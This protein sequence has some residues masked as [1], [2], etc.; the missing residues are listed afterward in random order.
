M[1]NN[2]IELITSMPTEQQCRDFYAKC[3]WT[4]GKPVCVHC[5]STKVYTIQGGKR[6][7]CGE[8]LCKKRFSVTCGTVFHAS[9]IPLTKWFMAVYL[10]INHKKGISSYQLGRDIGVTQKTGW[11]MLHRI[12]QLM[13][14]EDNVMLNTVVEIDETWI[15]GKMKNKHKAV[16]AKAH[17]SNIS[18]TDDKQAVMGYLQR[19][20]I[21]K[22]NKMKEDKTL[23]EQVKDNVLPEAV[24][25][26]DGL[27]AYKGLDKT[28]EAHEIVNHK[29]D[30]YVRGDIH[31]NSIEGAFGLFKRMVLGIYHKI[32]SKHLDRYCGEFCYRYNSRKIK[33]CD[34]FKMSLT[35]TEKRITYKALTGKK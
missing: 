14:P 2:L 21:L 20:G 30:E 16:R 6:Y 19:D 28:F 25:I 11:F 8:K 23:K 17:A 12:R 1:F 26:T 31:T 3:R 33:D 7:E 18:H 35:Q 34:R 13:M 32:D 15:N 22:L 4:D 10:C 9:N 27:N 24:V 5:G 29:E